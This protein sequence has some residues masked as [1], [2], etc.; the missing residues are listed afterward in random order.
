M[1]ARTSLSRSSTLMHSA[2]VHRLHALPP[3]RSSPRRRLNSLEPFL[4]LLPPRIYMYGVVGRVVNN[5][6]SRSGQTPLF[7]PVSRQQIYSGGQ[8]IFFLK[9]GNFSRNSRF[10]ADP[11]SPFPLPFQRGI[12]SVVDLDDPTSDRDQSSRH[13]SLPPRLSSLTTEIWNWSLIE[14][15]GR[16]G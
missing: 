5:D 15:E 3:E 12:Y 2:P 8:R 6:I 10:I 14:G 1:A 13:F 9:N 11:P 7:Q 4:L 16:G